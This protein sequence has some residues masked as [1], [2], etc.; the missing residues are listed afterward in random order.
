MKLKFF[1]AIAVFTLLTFSIFG[2]TAIELSDQALATGSDLI[3]IGECTNLKSE[4]V[5]R[6]LV[7][8]A[9][10]QVSEWIKGDGPAEI[11]V[12]L[13]GGIDINRTVP[14][15]MNYPGAPELRVGEDA[16]L[17]LARDDVFGSVITGFSQGKFSIIDDA[18]E[19]L[20]SRDLTTLTLS[21]GT[22]VVRG[23]TASKKKL[24]EFKAEIRGF[25]G[26]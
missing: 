21:T 15:G 16:F 20:V 3:L 9:T 24:T 22:G 6:V 5:D 13:P 10:L 7:T 26:N 12:T 11:V 2:T 25:V 19:K 4:W 1:T 23:G 17:F 14:V 18:G 8:R